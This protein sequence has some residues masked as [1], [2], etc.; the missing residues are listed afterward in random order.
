VISLNSNASTEAIWAGIPAITLG[1]H[2]TNPVTRQHIADINNLHRPHLANWLCML[3]YSQF[4]YDELMNGTAIQI[5]KKYH[6]GEI[7]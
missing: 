1:K 7:K 4:T 3:S 5:V 6:L 2:I